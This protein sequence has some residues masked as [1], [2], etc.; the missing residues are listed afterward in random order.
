[1]DTGKS[2]NVVAIEMI[3]QTLANWQDELMD[4][5]TAL[6]EIRAHI[7]VRDTDLRHAI[8]MQNWVKV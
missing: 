1:M 3:K 2:P 5:K 6:A 7:I 4:D 8:L